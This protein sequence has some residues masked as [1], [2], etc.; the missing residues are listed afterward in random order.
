MG[1][2]PPTHGNVTFAAS[3]VRNPQRD[4][5]RALA[6]GTGIVIVLYILTNLSYLLHCRRLASDGSAGGISHVFLRGI[7][8]A[9]SDRVAAAAMQ[10][11]MGGMGAVITAIL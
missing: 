3:E 7:S 5:P 4:L 6:F 1:S 2:S 11:I 8:G 10:V 9:Q